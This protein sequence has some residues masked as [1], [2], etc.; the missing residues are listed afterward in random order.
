MNNGDSH[1]EN[2]DQEIELVRFFMGP[3]YSA[4]LD[5]CLVIR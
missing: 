2:D 4:R 1:N 3:N 5:S